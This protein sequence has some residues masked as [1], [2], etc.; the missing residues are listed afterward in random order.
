MAQEDNE[1]ALNYVHQGLQQKK[2]INKLS[3]DLSV[4]VHGN[5]FI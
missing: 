2:S 3:N 4:Y 5:T 1:I